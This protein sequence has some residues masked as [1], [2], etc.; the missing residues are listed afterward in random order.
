MLRLRH[1]S[2]TFIALLALPLASLD[3]MLQTPGPLHRLLT[4]FR[5]PL[6]SLHTQLI[7][8][9]PGDWQIR[10]LIFDAFSHVCSVPTG[11]YSSPDLSLP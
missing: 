4:A 10:E 7:L 1:L 11:I 9:L 2:R 3:Q 5:A 6:I 8:A